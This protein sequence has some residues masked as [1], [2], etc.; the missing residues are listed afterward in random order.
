M[1]WAGECVGLVVDL[2]DLMEWADLDRVAAAFSCSLV[3]GLQSTGLL[4]P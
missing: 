4:V 1:S 2:L 3:T